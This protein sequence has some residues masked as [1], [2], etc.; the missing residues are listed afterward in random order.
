MRCV[1][2]TL[3]ISSSHSIDVIIAVRRNG[4]SLLQ[5]QG[6]R[7]L[8]FDNTAGLTYDGR[9]SASTIVS[10]Q[11]GDVLDLGISVL[12]TLP[13]GLMVMANRDANVTLAAKLL[14]AA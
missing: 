11:A 2:S 1:H 12:R 8:S 13:S 4:T 6:P 10:L 7:T 3:L 14:K 9:L 5:T